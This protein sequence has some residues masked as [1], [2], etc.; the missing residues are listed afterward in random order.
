MKAHHTTRS[1]RILHPF[2]FAL[3]PLLFLFAHNMSELT[4]LERQSLERLLLPSVILLLGT[5]GLFTCSRIILKDKAKAGILT[6]LLVTIIF[7]Y[8]HFYTLVVEKAGIQILFSLGHFS[9]GY[10]KLYGLISGVLI[11]LSVYFFKKTSRSFQTLT[12]FLNIFTLILLF[13]LLGQIFLYEFQRVR[14]QPQKVSYVKEPDTETNME[15]TL[16]D[17][18]YIILDAYGGQHVLYNEFQY[19]NRE[20]YDYLRQQGFYVAD[21]SL[22]NYPCTVFSLASSLNFDYLD[23]LTDVVG[24][25]STDQTIAIGLI[26]NNKVMQFLGEHG[27]KRIHFKTIYAPTARN[28]NAD[29]E[30]DCERGLISDRFLKM[31]LS[32]TILDPIIRRL[33]GTKRERI[34]CQFAKLAEIAAI[35]EPTFVFAHIIAPHE[36][37]VVMA[38]GE[39]VDPM[40]QKKFQGTRRFEPEGRKLYIEQLMYINKQMKTL[41]ENIL[42]NSHQ[43]PIIILQADHG[44]RVPP[45]DTPQLKWFDILNAYYLPGGNVSLLYPSISPVN[46]FRIM[47]NL[48]FQT[49]YELLPDRSYYSD[50]YKSPYKFTE[51]LN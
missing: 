9:F 50:M 32:T 45:W 49:S 25:N 5:G 43:K 11:L 6:T 10:N 47:F 31:Y 8:G 46:T 39:E 20:F 30:V 35:P 44:A 3:S 16:P 42:K 22:S 26:E 29:W 4:F 36:P 23:Q 48:Y 18:Y 34:Q 7:G 27:Y 33:S 2:V 24:T 37:Y 14:N 28:R 13:L 51:V 1:T 21:E 40:S 38:N 15:D 41:I 19:D 12:H 17:I